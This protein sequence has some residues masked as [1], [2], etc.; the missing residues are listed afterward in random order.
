VGVG[1]AP[2]TKFGAGVVLRVRGRRPRLVLGAQPGH[3]LCSQY[4]GRG[5]SCAPTQNAG[6][7]AGT[8]GT[9]RGKVVL[10][11]LGL[12]QKLCPDAEGWRCRLVPSAQPRS[13]LCPGY[14]VL[15]GRCALRQSLGRRVGTYGTMQGL[16]ARRPWPSGHRL[17][18]RRPCLCAT[19]GGGGWLRPRSGRKHQAEGA[20]PP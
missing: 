11:V 7:Q 3:R 17:P 2:R 5:R 18:L 20:L 4:Q 6:L 13:R 12:R 14:Q 19:M 8:Q 1:Y 9:T 15:A 16:R 10:K